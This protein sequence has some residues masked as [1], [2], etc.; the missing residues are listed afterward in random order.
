MVRW[1]PAHAGVEGN[2]HADATAKRAA[3]GG[4][5][6]AEGEYLGEASLSHLAR[7]TT[8]ARFEAARGWIRD[9]VRK[10]RRYRPPPGGRLRKGL[11]K[12]WKEL[13]GRFFQLLSGH[14]A[15]AV[16]LKRIDQAP[17]GKC[18]LCGSSES[19]SHHHLSI[20]CRRWAPEIQ[21]L[22][23]RV[24]KDCE[25]ESPRA[26]AA[27]LLLCDERATSALLEFLEGARVGRMPGLALGVAE[28]EEEE[29]ELGEME[30][31]PGPP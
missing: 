13:A 18:W 4:G 9:H 20:K 15:T 22:W 10:E 29:E 25:W 1:A 3:E 30:M 19:Q 12:V 8:E 24:E 21:R 31:W 27:R 6:R 28:E 5:D 23:K 16:H 14:A 17:N 2:E 26:P 7:K 11:G